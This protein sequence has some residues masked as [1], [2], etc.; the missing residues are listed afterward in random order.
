M[1]RFKL[2]RAHCKWLLG[3]TAFVTF[4]GAAVAQTAEPT[5]GSVPT[6]GALPPDTVPAPPPV[7]ATAA[8]A[9]PVTTAPPAPVA[10][11]PEPPAPQP[12]KPTEPFAFGDFTWLNGTNRQHKALLDSPYFTELSSRRQLHRSL[13]RPDRQHGRRLDRALAK[14]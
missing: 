3:V 4:E 6:S 10:A 7:A 5:P 13:N 1:D 8:A 2:L 14:Q 12:D 9:P 11:A